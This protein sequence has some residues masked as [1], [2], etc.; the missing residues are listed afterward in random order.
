MKRTWVPA[1]VAAALAAVLLLAYGNRAP[2]PRGAPDRP[3]EVASQ[4]SAAAPLPP[5]APPAAG[6]PA[7][8]APPDSAPTGGCIVGR[9]IRAASG[10]PVAGAG[11]HATEMAHAVFLDS[12]GSLGPPAVRTDSEGRFAL[13]ALAP[14]RYGLLVTAEGLAPGRMEGVEVAAGVAADAGDVV[15]GEG[16]AVEGIVH[17]DDDRPAAGA[18]VVLSRVL[19]GVDTV[20]DAGLP[21]RSEADGRYR[22]EHLAP[23]RYHVRLARGDAM[24]FEQTLHRPR[25]E[26]PEGPGIVE[27]REGETTYADLWTSEFGAVEGTV[28]DGQGRPLR[29]TVNLL[30]LGAKEPLPRVAEPAANGAYVFRGLVAGCYAL[31]L[32]GERREFELTRGE[33][34]RADLVVPVGRIEGVVEDGAGCPVPAV[35]VGYCRLDFERDGWLTGCPESVPTDALGRFGFADLCPGRYR[36]SAEGPQGEG[37]SDVIEVGPEERAAG[38][39]IVLS[40]LV[41][42]TVWVVDA[43]GKARSD[44]WVTWSQEGAHGG[45]Q[46]DGRGAATF[47]V[48]SGPLALEVRSPGGGEGPPVRSEVEVGEGREQS[49]RVI[50]E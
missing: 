46:V 5:P 40:P 36:L 22:V 18:A 25:P 27:V 49:A 17:G 50:V 3:V 45:E 41:T 1:L 11:V 12:I 9:A 7:D 38:V 20:G 30:V 29:L 6:S 48:R 44:A 37:A 32:A 42:L 35:A 31:V 24:S 14:G 39:R 4:P 23:G 26:T 33:H 8:G 28:T 19:P 21:V 34:R 15:L 16:G 47:R 43:A 10:L 2:A 13:P